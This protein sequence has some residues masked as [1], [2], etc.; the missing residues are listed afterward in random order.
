MNRKIITVAAFLLMFGGSL[1]AQ[2]E[3]PR[4]MDTM[5]AE[6]EACHGPGGVSAE[7]DVPSLAGM[8]QADLT[9]AIEEFYF[10]ERHC[11]T[12]TYRSDDRPKTPMNM[13]NVA[14]TLS[15][16]ERKEI[17]AYFANAATD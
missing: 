7:D 15:E 14:N 5:I 4:D 1:L 12:T 6:C 9:A 17:A 16:E 3:D 10:Y 2:G 8:S 13:C 11:T